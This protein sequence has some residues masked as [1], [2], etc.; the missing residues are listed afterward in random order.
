VRSGPPLP[1]SPCEPQAPASAANP[2]A[3]KGQ[4]SQHMECE[5]LAVH[6]SDHPCRIHKNVRTYKLAGESRHPSKRPRSG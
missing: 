1:K 6:L 5:M 4:S 3:R 2:I